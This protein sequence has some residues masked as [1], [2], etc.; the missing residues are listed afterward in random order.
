M[1]FLKIWQVSRA[2]MRL[3]VIQF[4]C[5]L[6]W[7]ST[8]ALAQ[9]E[10]SE[11]VTGSLN[12][13]PTLGITC[14]GNLALFVTSII[15]G[16]L[17]LEMGTRDI[18][19]ILSTPKLEKI[20]GIEHGYGLTTCRQG[21]AAN[22]GGG[23]LPTA[24]TRLTEI[25]SIEGNVN[26][27]GSTAE[28]VIDTAAAAEEAK[29]AEAAEQK[30]AAAA[31]KA[32]GDLKSAAVIMLS[33]DTANW[34]MKQFMKSNAYVVQSIVL[35]FIPLNRAK[36]DE[37][38]SQQLTREFITQLSECT[39]STCHCILFWTM[40]EITNMLATRMPATLKLLC[41]SLCLLPCSTCLRNGCHEC[42]RENLLR[43]DSQAD[44]GQPM[45][46]RVVSDILDNIG[47][48][49]ILARKPIGI[50]IPM[51]DARGD[52]WTKLL[53]KSLRSK[54]AEGRGVTN[55]AAEALEG[56]LAGGRGS[57]EGSIEYDIFSFVVPRLTE[58]LINL[59]LTFWF[60]VDGFSSALLAR[61]TVRDY[62]VDSKSSGFA[63]NAFLTEAVVKSNGDN[64]QVCQVLTFRG[65]DWLC[66]ITFMSVGCVNLICALGWALLISFEGGPDTSRPP[67]LPT[68]AVIIAAIGSPW[69]VLTVAGM[70][71]VVAKF[72]DFG[73]VVWFLKLFALVPLIG[74]FAV[75]SPVFHPGILLSGPV[76]VLPN[77]PYAYLLIAT[78]LLFEMACVVSWSVLAVTL[79]IKDLGRWLYGALQILIWLKWATG[80]YLLDEENSEA[81]YGRVPHRTSLIYYSSAF[82][83]NAVLAGVR[84]KWDTWPWEH[85]HLF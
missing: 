33:N 74:A 8:F 28:I 20:Q 51:N 70:V 73:S 35:P 67:S 9:F 77:H 81:F 19:D 68:V 11:G 85:N 40:E 75:I 66:I 13:F 15:R 72:D 44:E 37:K 78:G 59:V 5:W 57:E 42:N 47:A 22:E 58:V 12:N 64:S 49:D 43:A 3:L 82:W 10:I 41:N 23:D 39:C 21:N 17:D 30:V 65:R 80:S 34:S 14:V 56:Y 7:F 25:A 4:V 26:T 52:D 54:D 29:A 79:A 76:K 83:I 45:R 48:G 46:Q 62:L 16:R 71:D 55:M 6:G 38:V 60:R 50:C 27:S 2:V 61:R 18:I 69:M 32:E 84:C 1:A 36:I 63:A 24:S 31:E 53:L